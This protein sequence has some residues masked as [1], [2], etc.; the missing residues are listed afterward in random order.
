MCDQLLCS[1]KCL[2]PNLLQM[3]YWFEPAIPLEIQFGSYV[4]IFL[5]SPAPSP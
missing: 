2:Y 4:T 1:R 3:D 5:H